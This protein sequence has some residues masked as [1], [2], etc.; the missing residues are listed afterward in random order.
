MVKTNRGALPRSLRF[1]VG[2]GRSSVGVCSQVEWLGPCDLTADDLLY[3]PEG[4]GPGGEGDSGAARGAAAGRLAVSV[5]QQRRQ[6]WG[7]S[8][9]QNERLFG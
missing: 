8:Q 5:G 4:R 2:E 3:P 6:S 7:S 9:G 1:V